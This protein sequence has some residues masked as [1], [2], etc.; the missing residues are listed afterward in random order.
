EHLRS[1]DLTGAVLFD[2]SYVLYYVGFAFIQ[3]ERPAALVVNATG[4]RGMFVPRLEREHAQA[5]ALVQ[6]VA[7][8]PEYPS[9]RHPMEALARLLEEMGVRGPIGSDVAGYP[10]ALG[11]RGPT[12][13][14]LSRTRSRTT[15]SSTK[16]TS[17]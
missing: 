5:N 2:N 6:H 3:T 8:Y 7:D 11:Y 10:W 14:E 16:A 1:R 15:S 17:S 9:E 4:E 12:L 13:T